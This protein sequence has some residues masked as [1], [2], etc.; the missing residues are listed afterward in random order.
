[1][2]VY[3][4]CNTKDFFLYSPP[5]KLYLSAQGGEM[6]PISRIRTICSLLMLTIVC[7]GPGT[8]LSAATAPPQA[9]K[10]TPQRT[11]VS[12]PATDWQKRWDDTI[13]A[14]KKEGELLIYLNAPSEARVAIPEA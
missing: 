11:P 1:M 8:A 14:S 5:R 2:V 9:K 7:F 10:A 3:E 12:A 13:A 4:G 6:K